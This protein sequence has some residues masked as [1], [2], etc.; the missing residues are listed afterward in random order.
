MELVRGQVVESPLPYFRYGEVCTN[1][2]LALAKG[3]RI[4]EHGH[5]LARSGVVTQRN[6]DTVRGA[7]VSFYSFARVPPGRMPWGYLPVVPDL[8]VEVR[9]P[10]T[11]R[12]R[13]TE[14]LSAGVTTVVI[15]D[16]AKGSVL[17]HGDRGITL[18]LT[19]DDELHLPDLLG[20]LRVPVRRFFE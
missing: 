11:S 4:D 20:D 18:H 13:V 1:I 10:A 17:L 2:L 12:D 14:Y 19:N 7:D 5:L 6:P 16:D 9:D 3:D 8:V 15:A